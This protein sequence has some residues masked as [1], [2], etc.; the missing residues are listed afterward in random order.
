MRPRTKLIIESARTN[1][2]YTIDITLDRLVGVNGMC[3]A[4]ACTVM[5]EAHRIG[6]YCPKTMHGIKQVGLHR[7]ADDIG[8]QWG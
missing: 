4:F 5:R 2:D 3:T 1:T 7:Q 6:G 8:T